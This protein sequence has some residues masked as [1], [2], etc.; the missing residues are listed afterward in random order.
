MG[1]MPSTAALLVERGGGIAG[2]ASVATAASR[3]MSAQ[4][5]GAVV[6]ALALAS[7]LGRA[8]R[9]SLI[10]VYLLA[11]AA[12]LPLH[13]VVP[14]PVAMVVVAGIGAGAASM[15][16]AFGGVVQRDAP[17]AHRGRV[18]SWYQ[19]AIGLAY[20]LALWLQGSFADRYGLVPLFAI[21]GALT[22][23]VVVVARR[24]PGWVAAMDHE[25]RDDAAAGQLASTRPPAEPALA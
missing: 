13:A 21:G 16:A 15:F 18:L 10:T 4:G 14:L 12:L 17:A 22:A 19:G 23:V 2:D 3:L 9:S 6:G 24:T 8:R 1:L 5:I 11:V 25:V 20:G 7:L